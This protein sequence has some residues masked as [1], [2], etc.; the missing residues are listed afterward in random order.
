M[1]RTNV[2]FPLRVHQKF[3]WNIWLTDSAFD[4]TFTALPG[5]KLGEGRA[6]SAKIPGGGELE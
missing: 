5:Q 4:A 2:R 6:D 1:K 3:A